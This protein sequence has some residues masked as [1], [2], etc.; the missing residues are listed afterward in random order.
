M[1]GRRDGSPHHH[2]TEGG[3]GSTTK[4]EAAFLAPFAWC[5]RF[6]P[7]PPLRCVLLC[8][9]F[10]LGVCC[11]ASSFFGRCCFSPC[12]F[13]KV[14]LFSLLLEWCCCLS[15]LTGAFPFPEENLLKLPNNFRPF[16]DLVFLQKNMLQHPEGGRESS[17]TQ[18]ERGTTAPRKMRRRSQHHPKV[19]LVFPPLLGWCCSFPSASVVLQ[20]PSSFWLVLRSLRLLFGGGA[21]SPLP[22]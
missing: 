1:S 21:F 5:C 10:L 18:K 19:V 3:E 22:F 4:R 12:S 7:P 11:F 6:S 16:S 2:T 15:L 20:F 14:L 8:L 17:T 9:I 13:W